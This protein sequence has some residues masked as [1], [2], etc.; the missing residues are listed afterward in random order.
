MWAASHIT[1]IMVICCK[2]CYIIGVT[3]IHNVI[4][5]CCYYCVHLLAMEHSHAMASG[6]FLHKGCW[7]SHSCRKKKGVLSLLLFMLSEGRLPTPDTRELFSP[8]S[9]GN[10][11]NQVDFFFFLQRFSKLQQHVTKPVLAVTNLRLFLVWGERRQNIN[12][13]D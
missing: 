7:P 13:P 10:I 9:S 11:V 4:I 6:P 3:I 5:Y 12:T 2:K 1:Q 8:S